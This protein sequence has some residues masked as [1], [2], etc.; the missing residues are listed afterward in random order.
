MTDNTKWAREE[1][2]QRFV[3]IAEFYLQEARKAIVIDESALKSDDDHFIARA[4][5]GLHAIEHIQNLGEDNHTATMYLLNIAIREGWHRAWESDGMDMAQVL[6][7]LITSTLERERKVNPQRGSVYEWRK[8]LDELIP[9]LERQGYDLK[10]AVWA[11]FSSKSKLRGTASH[12]S[13]I[14]NNVLPKDQPKEIRSMMHK[15]TNPDITL[16]DFSK[17]SWEQKGILRHRTKAGILTSEEARLIHGVDKNIILLQ[18][19][20]LK[21]RMLRIK[22]GNI[23]EWGEFGIGQQEDLVEAAARIAPLKLIQKAAELL[24]KELDKKTMSILKKVF[25]G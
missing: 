11:F 10:D 1:Y 12:Y 19:D 20:D 16:R 23:L 3:D 13:W 25:D 17:W 24:E 5:S 2:E 18:V 7:D 14:V 8:I 22:M 9:A 21:T 15:V 6:S 4:R